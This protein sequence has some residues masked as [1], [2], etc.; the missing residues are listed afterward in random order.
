MNIIKPFT[1]LA[2]GVAMFAASSSFA[3]NH[4][5]TN[6]LLAGYDLPASDMQTFSASWFHVTNMHCKVRT[7]GGEGNALSILAMKKRVIVNGQILPEG[8]GTSVMVHAG[9][10][11]SFEI[12]TRGKLAVT[13]NGDQLVNLLCH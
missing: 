7:A 5:L 1:V 2:C 6:D 11:I 8:N 13:N 9:D 12:D 10:K 4:D 3:L